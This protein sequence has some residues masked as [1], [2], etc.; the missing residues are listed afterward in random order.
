MGI[1]MRA[2]RSATPL[3]L[4]L[5]PNCCVEDRGGGSI[6]CCIG[7][8]LGRLGSGRPSSRWALPNAVSHTVYQVFSPRPCI[9]MAVELNMTFTCDARQQAQAVRLCFVSTDLT[10]GGYSPLLASELAW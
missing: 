8:E 1:E 7:P 9:L 2:Q 10:S 5:C 4:Q 6:T 3:S